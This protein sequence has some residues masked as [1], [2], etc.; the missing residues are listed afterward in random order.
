MTWSNY[1]NRLTSPRLLV[2]ARR[3]DPASSLLAEGILDANVDTSD[4]NMI[5]IALW[6]EWQTM[7]ADIRDVGAVWSIVRNE[8]SVLAV[9]GDYPKLTFSKDQQAANGREG[10]TTLTCHFRAWRCAAAF[11]SD[12]CCGKL[13]GVEITNGEEVVHR[14]CL[15]RDAALDSFIE[16]TRM[17]QATGLE[18]DGAAAL[19]DEGRFHPQSFRRHPGTLEVPA[20]R[21]RT[22]LIHAAQREIPLIASVASEGATQTTRLDITQA[23]ESRGW[24]VLSGE[25]RS[26]YVDAA[27][28]GSLLVEPTST[29]GESDLR[30]SLTNANDHRFLH[31]RGAADDRPAWNQLVRE[32]VLC[33]TIS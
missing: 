17:H 22:A 1:R 12:C 21:L 11:E 29:E 3:G 10:N 30:L 4:A 18:E 20:E 16:W 25:G 24:L 23:S 6:R 19:A 26:L 31:L 32:F 5:R 8:Q 15:A 33:S 27:P 14:I 7:L 28:I 13:R 9:A 2:P